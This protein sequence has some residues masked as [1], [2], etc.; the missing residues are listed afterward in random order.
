MRIAVCVNTLGA[1]GAESFAVSLAK[2]YKK[3]GNYVIFVVHAISDERGLS[4]SQQL[5]KNQ[6]ELINI[7]SNRLINKLFFAYKYAKIFKK[8][9]IEVVH[10]NL[11]Q[12]DTYV[13]LSK[14]FYHKAFIVR[15]LHSKQPFSKYP[16][17]IHKWLFD[18]YK[19]N[20]GCGIQMKKEYAY[21]K[22]RNSIIAIDNGIEIPHISDTE[23]KRIR[24]LI[25]KKYHI[26]EEC[27]VF[28]QVG[29]MSPRF[30]N[31]LTKGHDFTFKAFS[32]IKN[33][34]IRILFIGD[35]KALSSKFYDPIY[36]TDSRFIFTGVVPNPIEYI[37]ASDI[38]LA[39]SRLEGLPIAILE[40]VSLG[41]PLICSSISQYN[42]FHNSSTLIANLPDIDDYIIK[43]RQMLGNLDTYTNNSIAV[44][45]LINEKYSISNTAN[46]YMNHLK[47]LLQN[48]QN[49]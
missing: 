23:K 1:G 21:T 20:F 17:V 18:L 41:K 33:K 42:L 14:I 25:R 26:A 16:Y 15:T 19:M 7:N 36:Y 22:L 5:T 3:M 4:L 11:E 34:N 46:T 9:N 32:R 39:P 13:A 38:I 47:S 12:S 29:T 43:I 49:E 35:N 45:N 31:V 27:I 40:A 24:L 37:I 48:Q 8:H 10:S 28:I 44:A 6:I 30:K 2:E